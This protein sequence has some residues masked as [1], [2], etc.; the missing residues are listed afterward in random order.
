MCFYTVFAVWVY[1]WFIN[2]DLMCIY[3][4]FGFMFLSISCLFPTHAKEYPPRPCPC[5]WKGVHTVRFAFNFDRLFRVDDAR[6]SF[7]LIFAAFSN[8]TLIIIKERTRSWPTFFSLYLG[9]LATLNFQGKGFRVYWQ[10]CL[11]FNRVYLQFIG[12]LFCVYLNIF[13]VW[14]NLYSI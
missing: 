11:Y 3:D 13:Q 6:A 7:L 4:Y 8:P 5:P 2:V 9:F 10:F 1:L 14:V 12:G